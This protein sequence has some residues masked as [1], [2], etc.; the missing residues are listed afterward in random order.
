MVKPLTKE[1]KREISTKLVSAVNHAL[2]FKRASPDSL[3]EV[4]VAHVVKFAS[5]QKSELIKFSM[6]SAGSRALDILE[7]NQK[8]KDKDVIAK[9]MPEFNKII[10]EVAVDYPK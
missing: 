8:L 5:S 9:V 4:A 1:D 3:T 2:A 10:D 7:R 6:I